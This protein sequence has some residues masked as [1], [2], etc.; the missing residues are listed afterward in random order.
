MFVRVEPATSGAALKETMTRMSLGQTRKRRWKWLLLI[1]PLAVIV[2]VVGGTYVYIHFIEPDPA[3]R[4]A[5]AS[6]DPSSGSEAD[7]ASATAAG[8]IDGTWSIAAGSKVQY[9]VQEVLNG[10]DNEATG[11]A[12]DVTGQFTIAGTTIDAA[13]FTVDMASFS[14]S[15]D[16][17][18]SQFRGRI[19]ETSKFP[20][21]TFELAAPITLPAIPDNLVQIDVNATGRFTLHGVTKELTVQLKARRNG[22]QVELNG[23]VPVTF[24]DYAIDDPSGGPAQVGKDGEMEFLLIFKKS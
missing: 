6:V 21:S 24:A 22:S 17:R 8:R 18:D 11:T 15:Q 13:S 10:Q 19:M 14:S 9:R 5:F 3:P 20:T 12:T 16:L 4:L 7:D 1:V 2:L 23:T